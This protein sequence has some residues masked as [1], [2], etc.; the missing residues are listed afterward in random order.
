MLLESMKKRNLHKTTNK[1]NHKLKSPKLQWCQKLLASAVSITLVQYIMHSTQLT[2]S[3]GKL[4]VL[5]GGSLNYGPG[6]Y[7]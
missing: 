6:M 5:N 1:N 7:F 2:Y 4:Y 3:L